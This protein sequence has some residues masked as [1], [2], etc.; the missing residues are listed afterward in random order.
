[1][2]FDKYI[3]KG[4][5]WIFSSVSLVGAF[6][7]SLYAL[8]DFLIGFKVQNIEI[9]VKYFLYLLPLGFYYVS[10]LFFSIALFIFLRRLIERKI[11]LIIQSFRIS[12]LRLASPLILF[13]VLVS[14][15]FLLGNQFFFPQTAEQL[16][17]IEKTYKKKQRD[18]GIVRN[19]WFLKKGEKNYVYYFVEY[20]DLSSKRFANLF[21]LN[22]E[23][24]SY[25]PV[26]YLRATRGHWRGK[27]ILVEEGF[28]Y[29]FNTG[30]FILMKNT[31]FNIGLDVKDL[32]LFSESVAF[33]TL[34]DLYRLI[35]KGKS[36][37]YNPDIYLGEILFRI[38]FSFLPFIL[39]VIIIFF[40]LK[41]RSVKRTLSIFIV[42]LPIIWIVFILPKI[43]TQKVNQSAVFT[44]IPSFIVYLLVLKGIHDL[45]KGFR[46]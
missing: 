46:L 26:E 33:L 14:A 8:T 10:P 11:D 39:S 44:A 36:W 19:F 12:P 28:K 7:V 18:E 16:W 32:E 23:K 15:I 30:N 20:L 41:T 24:K 2:L 40:F 6:L 34:Y 27:N 5:L 35:E 45:R 21:Y 9:G 43:G 37:G 29:E 1:M 4:F 13:A 42:L 31:T 22:A 17:F 3:L 25:E 38:N